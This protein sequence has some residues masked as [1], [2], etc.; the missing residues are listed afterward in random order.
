MQ[1]LHGDFTVL[2]CICTQQAFIFGQQQYVS[3]ICRLYLDNLNIFRVL[4][5]IVIHCVET[6][7]F[8]IK[9]IEFAVD[10]LDPKVS[11]PVFYNTLNLTGRNICGVKSI[12]IIIGTEFGTVETA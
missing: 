1:L 5:Y 10:S 4:F 6:F 11:V 8:L 12:M 7:M 3:V 2:V 9:Q